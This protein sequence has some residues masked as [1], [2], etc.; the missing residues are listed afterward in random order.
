M[1]NEDYIR[2][3]ELPGMPKEISFEALEILIPKGK[4]N[5]CKIKCN[6][7]SHGTGFFCNI[8]SEWNPMKVLMT[9]NHVLKKEDIS[10]GKKIHFT[11]NNDKTYYEIEIDELRKIYTDEKYDITI[12]EIKKNDKL[13]E[14]SFFDIDDRIF[15]EN[16]NKIFKNMQIYLLHYPKGNEMKC[17][18]GLIKDIEEEENCTIRH[19]CS[20]N[21]GSSGGPLINSI[22]FQVIGIHKGAANGAKQYN[23]GTFL[24]QPL[25]NFNNKKD[26]KKNENNKTIY[27]KENEI[28][29]NKNIKNEIEINKKN[30]KII[31]EGI[32]E[33]IIKYKIDNIEYSKDIRIFGDEFVNINKN[34]C[35]I[36]I[37]GNE[38]E[39]TSHLN[40][41]KKQLNN[42][43]F[44]ITL[45][46]IKQI[47]D[48]GAM[49]KGEYEDYIPIS[50]LPDI[51][52]WNTEKVTNMSFIFSGCSSLL[53]LP[54]ISKWNTENVTNMGSMFEDCKLL[55]SLP[56]I[57]KWNTSNV[58][59]MNNLFYGCSSLSSLPDISKWNTEKV[60]DMGRMFYGCSSLSSLPDI[61]KWNTSNVIYM[62]CMFKSCSFLLSL[63]DI[64]KWNT[65][66][67]MEFCDF[68]SGGIFEDCSSLSLLPDI[69]KWD[70][71]N[72]RDL[73]CMFRDCSSLSSLPDISKWNISNV[74]DLRAMF[75]DC[76]SL[77]SLPD[78]SKWNTENVTHMDSM[79]S[80]CSSLSSLPDISKW[81]TSKVT[82]FRY[83]FS[84]CSSLLSLP[85]LSKWN[86]ENVTDM[87]KMFEDCK[88]LSSL[89]DI[90]KWN[91]SK[92][93]EMG[94]MF[95]H[96]KSLLSLPDISKW[97]IEKVTDME[98]MFKGCKK[99]KNIP[100]KFST[101]CILL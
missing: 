16:P 22:N 6:D 48:M 25:K 24:Q 17:S 62:N 88:S 44:E 70:I 85:D 75:L 37:T 12:I 89:P 69:S 63:P 87:R 31:N 59:Y 81:N 47:T 71:S 40:I 72:V 80:G 23:L 76:K 29:N 9:N 38:F 83:T 65:S 1:E 39:L 11:I 90:S 94:S 14:I 51:S 27:L 99:L 56:D 33:I 82:T 3:K 67:I 8:P 61:S 91:T 30:D 57:S 42:N 36:I 64:S 97:N 98:D 92:V 13:D 35:K 45:K 86:T 43:I 100:K 95:E 21:S 84:E 10:I 15:E 20:S 5:I 77:S 41:N 53:S 4:R 60:T 28:N 58:I 46:G 7:G 96:C 78:I 79:F 73:R 32:D 19:L 2:E 74:I 52:K 50:S 101:V 18:I 54:D 34:K 26:N 66:N 49:F 68:I 55:S 93:T